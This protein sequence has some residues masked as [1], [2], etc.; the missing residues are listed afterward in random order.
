MKTK[1]AKDPVS[2][3]SSEY[4][5]IFILDSIEWWDEYKDQYDSSC[6]LILTYDFG[7][8][9]KIAELGG[10]AYYLDHLIDQDTMQEN[11]FLIYDFF[12]N[13]HFDVDG[14]DI[15]THDDIPFGFS[16]RVDFWNDF[17]FY[18]RIRI[19]LGVLKEIKLQTIFI[20][21]EN[22]LIASVLDEL[23]LPYSLL[24]K[25]VQNNQATYYF[26]IAQWMDEKLRAKGFRGFLYW[27]REVITAAYGYC[28]PWID[29]FLLNKS[30]QKAIFIQEYHPTR[31]LIS[32]LR[33]DPNLRIVLANFSRGS[34]LL[35]H[36]SERLIPVSGSLKKYTDEIE[37]FKHLFHAKRH[38]K[39]ILTN[40]DDISE[41]AY[42][43]IETRIFDRMANTLRT[44]DSVIHYINHNP[45]KLEIL[46][47]NIG[48]TATL[49]DCVCKSKNIPSYMIINGM[50]GN[51]YLDEAKHAS[52]IN[53]YSVSIKE[54][55]FRKM[56]NVVCLGDPRMDAYALEFKSRK[57]NKERPTVT[58]GAAA[59][60][61]VDL[62]SYVAVEFEFM[63]DILTAFKTVSSKGIFLDILIK[64]RANGYEQQYVNFVQEFFPDL[65][66]EIVS[67]IPIKKVLEKT[68]FYISTYSQTILEASC[69]GIP[70]VFYQK[71]DEI[72]DAPFDGHS[73]LVTVDNVNDLIEA[74]FDFQT[75]NERYNPFLERTT[76]E[77]YIGPLDGHNLQRNIDFVYKLLAQQ[78][79]E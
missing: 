15:F 25:N 69:L 9:K 63:Y 1:T 44:L 11:N 10:C 6:D 23:Q 76:M 28:M 48:H 38:A 49:V 61:N 24:V 43:T 57:L 72:M 21:S 36:F 3:L 70:C 2:N 65:H 59:F 31:G 45:I 19:C 5:N 37:N 40:G 16:F 7:L 78:E 56:N 8:K 67:T 17:T 77:R 42:R 12:R 74:F 73:E 4:R 20:G 75:G 68:D 66:I 18:T 55:Y 51:D 13:W 47:A 39:L 60:S 79:G 71:D 62:N 50:L 30:H 27:V 41:G 14:K 26:P 29:K 58:I 53:S 22:N 33:K 54:N 52:I 34:K 46:I 32:R 64:V 35:D